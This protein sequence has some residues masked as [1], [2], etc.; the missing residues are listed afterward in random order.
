ML[1]AA[2]VTMTDVDLNGIAVVDRIQSQ[3]LRMALA[4]GQF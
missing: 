2:G 3:A 1:L 4:A